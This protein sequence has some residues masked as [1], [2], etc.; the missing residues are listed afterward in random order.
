MHKTCADD[1]L[2]DGDR[3]ANPL[4]QNYAAVVIMLR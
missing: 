2:K 3:L 1:I 4:L